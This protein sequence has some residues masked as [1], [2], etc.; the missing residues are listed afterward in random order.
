MWKW[1]VHTVHDDLDVAD[2]DRHLNPHRCG[3]EVKPPP[4][5]EIV[6]SSGWPRSNVG[7]AVPTRT[8]PTFLYLALNN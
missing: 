8:D 5:P 6:I 3:A 1:Q 2:D 4:A 7:G